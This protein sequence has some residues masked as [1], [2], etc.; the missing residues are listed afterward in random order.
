MRA[1]ILA[2]LLTATKKSA[3]LQVAFHLW[4]SED[5]APASSSLQILGK[6]QQIVILEFSF[7][8]GCET[9]PLKEIHS[10]LL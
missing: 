1:E 2:T 3:I 4:G 8:P 6:R 7:L 9:P 10:L 5:P